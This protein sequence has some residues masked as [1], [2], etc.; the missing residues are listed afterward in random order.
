MK[1]DEKTGKKIPESRVDEVSIT[2]QNLK[3][4]DEKCQ[5]LT[6]PAMVTNT[7]LNDISVSLA[8]LVDIT[9]NILNRMIKAEKTAKGNPSE[10]EQ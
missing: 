8:I 2:L 4:L 6:S 7:L 10:K 5:G 3:D 9:G 1:Y